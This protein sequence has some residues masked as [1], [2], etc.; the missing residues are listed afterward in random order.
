VEDQAGFLSFS[1]NQLAS[2]I[3]QSEI[4]NLKSEILKWS[5][6]RRGVMKYPG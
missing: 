1:N 2:D 4:Q 6:S 5:Q 3:L